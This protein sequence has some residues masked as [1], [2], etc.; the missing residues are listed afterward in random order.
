M[1]LSKASHNT[2]IT[3]MCYGQHG[4]GKISGKTYFIENALIGDH[5]KVIKTHEK[6]RYG[7]ATTKEITIR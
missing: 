5:V 2:E 6:N 4:V 1:T 3:S 7:F